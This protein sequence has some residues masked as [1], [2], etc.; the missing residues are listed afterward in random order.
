MDSDHV[1]PFQG[2][3]AVVRAH[4]VQSF[5][6]AAS[7]NRAEGPTGELNIFQAAASAG[8]IRR[9][10]SGRVG[11]LGAFRALLLGFDPPH[12]SSS[13]MHNGR[14]A[15]TAPFAGSSQR[16]FQPRSRS[17]S[18]ALRHDRSTHRTP[19]PERD[20]GGPRP[21]T[22]RKQMLCPHCSAGLVPEYVPFTC[23]LCHWRSY[24]YDEKSWMCPAGCNAR[25]CRHCCRSCTGTV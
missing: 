12:F 18:L 7:A 13:T 5:R 3:D 8:W 19:L 2:A 22:A 20:M 9:A 6:L 16:T 4:L 1:D 14:V 24:K 10:D 21:S 11:P 17:P 23:Q 15:A 25:F